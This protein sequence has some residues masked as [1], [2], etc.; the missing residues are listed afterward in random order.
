MSPT[1]TAPGPDGPITAIAGTTAQTFA[2]GADGALWWRQLLPT[3]WSAWQSFG[4]FI[5]STPA[6]VAL[7]DGT[8]YVFARGGD[9]A[10]WWQGYNG[11]KWSGWASLGG[12]V[13]SAPVVTRDGSGASL[14]A[15]GADNRLYRNRLTGG[16]SGWQS[17]G[18][19]VTSRPAAVA[20]GNSVFVAVRGVDFGLWVMQSIDGSIGD[21][22]PLGGLVTAH[23]AIGA[24]TAGVSVLVRGGDLGLYQNRFAG[25]WSGWQNL[26]GG[27]NS[28][29]SVAASG[30]DIH[31]FVRG[32]D[33][34]VYWE[35]L[36]NGSPSLWQSAGGLTTGDPA[37]TVDDG[38]LIVFARGRDSALWAQ[39]YVGGWPGWGRLGGVP[40]ATSPIAVASPVIT[41]APQAPPAGFGFDTCEAP[42]LSAMA[43]W[44]LASPFTSAG[45][46]I[47]GVN[48][49][50][51]NAVLNNANWINAVIAQGWRLIPIYVGLQAPCSPP[52]VG[53][54]LSTD[55][56]AAVAQGYAA[57]AD[58]VAR[59]GIAG[60]PAGSPIY[61]DMEGYASDPGCSEAVRWFTTGWVNALHDRWHPAGLY[62][63]Q[64]STILDQVVVYDNP[65][66]A[67]VDAVWIAAW[68]NVPNL[69]GFTGPCGI[70]DNFWVFH[71]RLHQF[72]GGHNETWGGVTLN[73]DSNVVDGPLAPP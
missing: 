30:T 45:I 3:G 21:W 49:A 13:T 69:F 54:K 56:F 15:V 39:R 6:A 35:R 31:V 10:V 40:I 23:P 22:S 70:P 5:T 24:D 28:S 17:L 29:P 19:F 64:C 16:F 48:R 50:C 18:G 38:G 8:V 63:S 12:F 33:D 25:A 59:A 26:G 52:S 14:F 9:G 72:R 42:N 47:G 67:R 71:Q 66:Y 60:L 53:A 73:V 4:G 51:P 62:G 1:A 27:L 65:R 37:A 55:L 58:A 20:S 7:A 68:N 41:A 44:R 34:A 43:S 36:S 57:G 11:T 46:Y 61:L 2:A 32:T